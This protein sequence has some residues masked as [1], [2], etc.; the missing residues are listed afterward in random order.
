[1]AKFIVLCGIDGAGKSFLLSGF[2]ENPA[3]EIVSY[4][5]KIL[6]DRLLFFSSLIDNF[7]FREWKEFDPELKF[8]YFNL[9]V[10]VQTNL[11]KRAIKKGKNVL[12]DSYY[13]K[14]LAKKEVLFGENVNLDLWRKLPKPDFVIFLDVA[15]ETAFERIKNRL[16]WGE[17]F[18][19]PTKKDFVS[20]Q[21]QVRKNILKEISNVP[22]IILDGNRPKRK[23]KEEFEKL[24]QNIC[25]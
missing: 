25:L 11:I 21:L 22:H 24:I 14:F 20:F 17:Y 6:K 9:I 13:Y 2:A 19:C 5:K 23:L 12:C 4:D 7:P 3:F 18:K 8:A 15:P 10:L 16:H 1:M